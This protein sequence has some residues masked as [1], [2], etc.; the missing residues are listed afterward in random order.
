MD[1]SS[2]EQRWRRRFIERGARM[3]DDA[4]I[5][6][7]TRTGLDTRVRQFLDIWNRAPGRGRQWLDVGCGAG[8]YT[9]IL[10][11]QGYE[12]LG[13]DYSSP[14]LVKA[15]DRSPPAID[16][17]AADIH[18]LPLA[19]GLADGVL[20]FGV[21]Q[22]LGG[23]EAAIGELA[24]VARVDGEVWVDA[25]NARC[26]PTRIAEWRRIRRGRSPHLRYETVGELRAVMERCGFRV[27]AVE[28]LPIMPGR[29]HRLQWLLESR[30]FRWLIRRVP[31]L[32]AWLSHSFI[33]RAVREPRSNQA[34]THT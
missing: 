24:R 7:W 29:L 33:I 5:A 4:G 9:R 1:S 10:D 32:G 22:A 3:D 16:W 30:W 8:T 28:W 31:V 14:S 27:I 23:S 13:L 2:F 6:G 17:V 12:V 15:R 19:N 21:M 25:L 34:R 20:C 26:L 11:E 18:A